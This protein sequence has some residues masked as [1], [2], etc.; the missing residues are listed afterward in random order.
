M[1]N[2]LICDDE[3]E[4][5]DSVE[6]YLKL[7]GFE[8]FK[9]YNG[10]QA[11]EIVESNDIHCII[12]DIMMPGADGLQTTLSI[13]EK[14]NIP[15][16]LLSAKSEDTDKITGLSFGADDYITKPY[17]PLELVAR[18]KSQVRRYTSLGSLEKRD[19][20]LV[21][22]ALVC[23]TQAKE[24]TVDGEPVKLTATEYGIVECLMKNLGKVMST[25]QIYEEV[26]HEPSYSTEKTVTV[27]IRRIREKI[28]TD[29]KEPRYLKVVWG[30]GY[31]ME[32]I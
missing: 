17:N 10:A 20:L 26:W 5:V 18:V 27:H 32:K 29:P 3:R 14:Y 9:A 30:I 15:I 2:V 4:I 16:I 25:G 21:T 1:S 11:M 23:D 8:V 24:V 12:M 6:V 7:E 13:R 28:E 22:G 31:K 19:G